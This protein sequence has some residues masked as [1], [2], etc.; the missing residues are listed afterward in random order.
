MKTTQIMSRKF[1]DGAIS[2]NHKTGWFNATELLAI[3]NK[4]RV[5]Q[6]EQE[7]RMNDYLKKKETKEFIATIARK[8]EISEVVKV[9]KG[10]SGGTWVHPLIL[11]DIAMWLSMDFKYQAMQW[12][13]DNLL[14]YRDISGD[15]YKTLASTIC[16]KINPSRAGIMIPEI[17]KQIKE[18]VGVDDWNKASEFQLKRRTQIQKDIIL[19]CKTPIALHEAVRIALENN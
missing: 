5:T 11:I 13:Q 14:Q 1:L 10:R 4:Y 9:T 15:D 8:E 7:K 17:A 19:L 18:K 3:A 16:Q 12:L 2:Q 6:G